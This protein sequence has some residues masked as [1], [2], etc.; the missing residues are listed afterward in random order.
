MSGRRGRKTT[1][2]KYV[3]TCG[4]SG[5]WSN[6]AA[7]FA[8]MEQ[9]KLFAETS[10]ADWLNIRDGTGRDAATYHRDPK[11]GWVRV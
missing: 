3:A 6:G 10:T 1:S 2:H 4:G 7:R 8:T 5:P 9:C 11:R